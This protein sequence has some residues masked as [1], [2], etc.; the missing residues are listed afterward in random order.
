MFAI[1]ETG[2]K[3]FRVEEGRSLKVAKLDVQAGGEITLDKVLLV[4]AG[5]EVKIGQP[6]V[7]GASVQCEVVDHGRDKKIIIF[8]KKRRKDYR[9]KQGHRQ[10]FT[11]LKVKSIQG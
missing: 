1:V 7:D 5:A 8:K 2:G 9:R 3:Q 4:G 10:D 6:F 11:L